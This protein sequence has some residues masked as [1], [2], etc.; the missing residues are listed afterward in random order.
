MRLVLYFF[1]LKFTYKSALSPSKQF[2]WKATHRRRRCSHSRQQC[3]KSACISA[4]SW[5]VT[6]FWML[7]TV[8]GCGTTEIPFFG[9]TFVHVDGS[10]TGSIVVMQH[11]SVRNLWSDTT[12]PFSE[13]FNDLVIVL[14][15]NC[16]SLRLEFL[17][18]NDHL[19]LIYSNSYSTQVII[20]PTFDARLQ[21]AI[22]YTCCDITSI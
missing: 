9:Q 1:L 14:F 17:M 8:G 15:I 18:N 11:P 6:T 3:W 13:S 12:N 19:T 4:L 16:L 7:S 22:H 2:P 10:V 20:K 5:S 21:Q